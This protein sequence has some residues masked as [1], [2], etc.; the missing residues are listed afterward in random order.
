MIP[1][2]LTSWLTILG[3]FAGPLANQLFLTPP[4]APNTLI[5]P[6]VFAFVKDVLDKATIPGLSMGIVRLRSQSRFPDI[7]LATWGRRT[8]HAEDDD[9]TSD[10]LF[11]LA[12]CSKAFLTSAVGLVIDDYAQGRNTTPLPAGVQQLNWDTKM[13]ALLPDEWGLRDE[14]VESRV[15]LR[16]ALSHTSGLPRHDFSYRPGETVADV[17]QRLKKLPTA[18]ELRERW[19][20]NNQMYMVGAHI[21]AKLTNMPYP[22]FVESR[23][24]SPLNM[25]STTFSPSKAANTGKLTQS[26]TWRGPRRIPFWFPDEVAELFAGAGGVISNAVDMTKWL[27]VLLNRGVDPV[28]NTTII[29][30]SVLTETTTAHAIVSG[31][32]SGDL[33]ITGYGMGWFRGSYRGHDV[34]WHSGAIPGFSLLAAFLPQDNMGVVLLANMD[35]KYDETMDILYRVIDEALELPASSIPTSPSDTTTEPDHA[36]QSTSTVV[37]SEPLPLG[38]EA[39]VGTY[40]NSAYGTITLCASFGASESDHCNHVLGQF[41][42]VDAQASPADISTNSTHVLYAAFP[43]VWSTHMRLRH[44][45]RN[46]FAVTL[47]ALFPHGYGRDTTPFEQ[48]ESQVG[49]GRAEFVVDGDTGAVVGFALITEEEAAVA[50]AR[51]SRDGGAPGAI[52]D[53]W[54]AKV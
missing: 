35:E 1:S 49:V 16:D 10:T 32:A 24:F 22:S 8:E 5:T 48:Y 3:S 19:L 27:A 29:P 4:T 17:L 36:S 38:L 52:G 54:F 12:S 41:A 30:A 15:S 40:H 34:A 42:S 39:Y 21:V 9:M 31:T 6:Q 14:W 37:E 23:I 28:T 44:T 11:A 33:S 50:R 13:Q 51:A 26:W 20:Y 7:Q 47:S 25:S 2:N 46:S 45:N 18:Y 53:A 43:R